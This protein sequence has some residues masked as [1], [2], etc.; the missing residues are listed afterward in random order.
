MSQLKAVIPRWKQQ[1]AFI[2]R[3]VWVFV[4]SENEQ[5]LFSFGFIMQCLID[6]IFVK[7]QNKKPKINLIRAVLTSLL[8][9]RG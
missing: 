5:L 4:V 7:K 6:E 9:C 3:P 1:W 8:V 2:I